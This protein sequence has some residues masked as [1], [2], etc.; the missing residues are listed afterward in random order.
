MQAEHHNQE[1]FSTLNE[2]EDDVFSFDNDTN[3]NRICE[4]NTYQLINL[5]A[6]QMA[7]NKLCVT[8]RLVETYMNDFF[9]ICLEED[10]PTRLLKALDLRKNGKRNVS[11]KRT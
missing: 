2:I 4:K 3:E 5:A 6:L 10:T 1:V 8:K 11:N 7:I 9:N